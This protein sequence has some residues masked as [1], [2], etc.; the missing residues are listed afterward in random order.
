MLG[1]WTLSVA[2]TLGFIGSMPLIGKD[3]RENAFSSSGVK[4]H[5]MA[6]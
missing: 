6:I 1:G 2:G 4:P 5:F 3:Y